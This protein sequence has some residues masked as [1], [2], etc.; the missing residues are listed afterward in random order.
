MRALPEYEQL[1]RQLERYL[2]H[3]HSNGPFSQSRLPVPTTQ[4]DPEVDALVDLACHVHKMHAG[5]AQQLEER[6]LTRHAVLS[7]QERLVKE[8]TDWLL[9]H[10][11]KQKHAFNMPQ[12]QG[13]WLFSHSL[14][15]KSAFNMPQA[16]GGWLFS[17]SL[18]QKSM[19]NM[20]Q[21]QGSWLFSRSL[22][23][24]MLVAVALFCFLLG[25]TL[26]ALAAPR[27]NPGNPLYIVKQW[28]QGLQLP[29]HGSSFNQAQAGLQAARDQLNVLANAHRDAY[30]QALTNLD[31]QVNTAAQLI[32]AVPSGPNR[33]QLTG[34][35]TALKVDARRILRNLLPQCSLSER[36][37]TTE[38]LGRLGDVVTQLNS[39]TISFSASTPIDNSSNGSDTAD[40]DVPS[41]QSPNRSH[42]G[43]NQGHQHSHQSPGRSHPTQVRHA[44][45]IQITISIRGGNLYLGGQ[46]LINGVLI[47]GHGT[48]QNGI[49]TF[50]VTW[51]SSQLPQTIGILN[52]DGTLAQTT[53]I[54]SSNSAGNGNGGENQTGKEIGDHSQSRFR[55][56]N[57]SENDKNK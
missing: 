54:L 46:L 22:K 18:K 49:Y 38:E 37:I 4:P 34:E 8:Q 45:P 23:A 43:S 13:G 2:P 5:F 9:S 32:N 26:I 15:Q 28:E 6:I 24:P 56:D 25:T 40:K 10:S 1:Q 52:T 53:H 12:A 39:A 51:N 29:W 19:F 33:D 35:L 17:H 55:E 21:A 7:Q 50:V 31:K 57:G 44:S 47:T 41:H 14:K 36:L 42:Q 27:A 16:Q 30:S 20:P 48:L 3:R 11:S